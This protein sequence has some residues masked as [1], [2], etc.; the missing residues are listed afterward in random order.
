MPSYHDT[1]VAS[2]AQQGRRTFPYN[3]SFTCSG[4]FQPQQQGWQAHLGLPPGHTL[5]PLPGFISA[6]WG[7]C[8]Q[9]GCARASLFLWPRAMCV[10]SLTQWYIMDS[11]L[12]RPCWAYTGAGRSLALTLTQP[13]AASSP[14]TH[15]AHGSWDQ[16]W[17]PCS[18]FLLRYPSS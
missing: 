5:S 10:E 4:T 7:L 13:Q 12:A 18:V 14:C 1:K 15:V 6:L 2:K 11:T 16:G 17:T 8:S 3:S 9:R